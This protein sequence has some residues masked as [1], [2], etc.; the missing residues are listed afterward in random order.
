MISYAVQQIPARMI[1]L[2]P[3]DAETI[4][5]VGHNPTMES[6]AQLLD[7]GEGASDVS[8]AMAMGFSTSAAA[9]LAPEGE[10]SEVAEGSANAADGAAALSV[11]RP[12]WWVRACRLGADPD[13]AGT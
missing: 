8:L 9:V 7:D 3:G 1:R 4:L 5:V 13:A 10:W 2:A 12:G 11:A 6:L